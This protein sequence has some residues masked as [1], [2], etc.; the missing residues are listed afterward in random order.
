MTNCYKHAFDELTNGEISI[1]L[2]KTEYVKLLDIPSEL[3]SYYRYMGKDP[4]KVSRG[5]DDRKSTVRGKANRRKGNTNLITVS[6]TPQVLPNP[7]VPRPEDCVDSA[8]V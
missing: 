3:C 8:T 1:A 2:N 5:G 6:T 7:P 4:R